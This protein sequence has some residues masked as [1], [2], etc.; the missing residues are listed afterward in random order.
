[1]KAS[2]RIKEKIKEFEG[3]RLTAYRCPAG[4]WT[5]GYGHTG[6]D[7]RPGR[8]IDQQEADRLFEGDIGK[9]DDELSMWLQV[10]GVGEL[11]QHQYDA[12]VSFAYNVGIS[13]LRHSTLLKKLKSGETPEA[14]ATEFA[15]WVNAGGKRSAG[16]VIRRASEAKIFINGDYS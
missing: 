11:K 16:L 7:V 15:R 10:E 9:F 14:V 13:A 2:R 4:V 5:I 3:C 8:Q 6:S 12:L 1:M